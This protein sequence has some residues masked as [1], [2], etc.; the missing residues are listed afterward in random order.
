MRLVPDYTGWRDHFRWWSLRL[1]WLAGAIQ[2]AWVALPP[3]LKATAPEWLPQAVTGAL[4]IAGIAGR[5]VE[6][7]PPAPDQ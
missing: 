3:D 2:G 6:Q 4:L 5:L 7:D 1:M